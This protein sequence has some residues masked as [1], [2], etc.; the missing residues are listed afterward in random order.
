MSFPRG[1][2][3]LEIVYEINNP[4]MDY[5]IILW[6]TGLFDAWIIGLSLG[7]SDY[8]LDYPTLQ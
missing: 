4:F 8:S 7:L 3:R 5:W 6:I 1:P 2:Q